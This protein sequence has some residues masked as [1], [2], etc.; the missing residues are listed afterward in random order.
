MSLG[1]I[2]S[3]KKKGKRMERIIKMPPK[4]AAEDDKGQLQYID[5]FPHQQ[6]EKE[7]ALNQKQDKEQRV[8]VDKD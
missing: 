1:Q 5:T 4:E 3:K 2:F 7:E 8:D 6:E